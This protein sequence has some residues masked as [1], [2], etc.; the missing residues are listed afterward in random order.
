MVSPQGRTLTFQSLFYVS[1]SAPVQLNVTG[2]DHF[3]A[4]MDGKVVARGNNWRVIY[5]VTVNLG[6]G[7]H[8]LTVT[9]TQGSSQYGP[10]LIFILAQNQGGCYNCGLNGEWNY[11]TCG[12]GC[13]SVC[14]CAW[15][16]IWVD[17]PGCACRCP[18]ENIT[19]V[20]V[21]ERAIYE[22]LML[23][24]QGPLI[25]WGNSSC[26]SGQYYSQVSC[27][28]KCVPRF[29]GEGFV[30]NAEVGVCGCV[31]NS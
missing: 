1:C 22:S 5:S 16:Q 6:C 24:Y 26:G 2:D 17:Y 4:Y 12:C 9:V 21:E 28:C 29:C 30:W 15:P 14:G 10:G 23:G 13:L 20:S 25:N 11:R 27:S 7:S 3:T 31:F 19:N 18:T 8:N